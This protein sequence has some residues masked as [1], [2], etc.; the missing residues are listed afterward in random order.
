MV[1]TVGLRKVIFRV[2]SKV[3]FFSTLEKVRPEK[4]ISRVAGQ[5]LDIMR[6]ISGHYTKSLRR[7]QSFHDGSNTIVFV[8]SLILA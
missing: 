2:F 6:F 4:V 1:V 8:S 7:G 5:T 3:D